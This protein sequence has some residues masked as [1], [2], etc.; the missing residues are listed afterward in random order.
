MLKVNRGGDSDESAARVCHG[1]SDISAIS[2]S[3]ADGASQVVFTGANENFPKIIRLSI[4]IVE[5][6]VNSDLEIDD[7]TEVF[8]ARAPKSAPEA[9]ALPKLSLT[10][11]P[12]VA[13]YVRTRTSFRASRS[14]G[15]L[16]VPLRQWRARQ[17]SRRGRKL[18]SH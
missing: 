8:S 16:R 1:M 4:T 17:L 18:S 13:I 11:F 15:T 7:A 10:A 2:T 6:R 3:A 14:S 9:C 5:S 12:L